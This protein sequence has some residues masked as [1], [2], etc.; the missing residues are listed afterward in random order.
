M[1]RRMTRELRERVKLLSLVSIFESLSWEELEILD[2]QLT[3]VHCEKGEYLYTPA[4]RIEKLYMLQKG[5][6]RE[7]K[8]IDD[9][10]LTLMVLE[11]GMVFGELALTRQEVREVYA[12][13]M[14]PSEVAVMSRDQLEVLMLEKP[15]VGVKVAHA[16]S[17]RLRWYESRLEDVTLKDVPARLASLIVAL[18]E[19]E[20]VVSTHNQIKI[21]TRY[22]HRELGTVIGVKRE[23]VTRAFAQ[24]QDAGAV[25]LR[26]RQIFVVDVEI[27]RRLAR[28]SNAS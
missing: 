16:L 8:V 23:A 25:E 3:K 22:T 21:P 19:S 11:T 12:Q 5:R 15:E 14:E 10:E 26:R 6:V 9:R 28:C 2:G 7:Y 20:G 24:L 13:A 4:D 1:F 17:E 18:I 27:L